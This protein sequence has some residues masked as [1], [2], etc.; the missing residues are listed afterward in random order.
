[1]NVKH[2]LLPSTKPA[3]DDEYV[4]SPNIVVQRKK[5]M[6][7]DLIEDSMEGRYSN[8]FHVN[9]LDSALNTNKKSGF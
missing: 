2:Q 1:M 8:C 6:N 7:L 5:N 4:E 9:P 3:Y